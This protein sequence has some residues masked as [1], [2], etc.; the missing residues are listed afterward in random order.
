MSNPLLERYVAGDREQVWRD[1]VELG[2][3]V[4]SDFYYPD[5]KAVADETMRRARHNI[6]A[7]VEKLKS[8][9][10]TFGFGSHRAQPLTD[11]LEAIQNAMRHTGA[12]SRME[13]VAGI[14]PSNLVEGLLEKM[15]Q[16]S[17]SGFQPRNA[18]EES[19]ATMTQGIEKMR[20]QFQERVPQMEAM[21]RVQPKAAPPFRA[22]SKKIA[23]ELD[24]LEKKQ[25]GP[26]PISLRAW[27]ES[28]GSVDLTGIHEV[29]SPYGADDTCGALQ[30]FQFSDSLKFAEMMGDEDDESEGMELTL[31]AADG[32]QYTVQVP[33]P[34]ADAELLGWSQTFVAHL[35]ETFAWG[36]F[37]DWKGRAE[38]PQKEID[39][40]REGLLPL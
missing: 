30:V 36:G 9:G 28:I 21:P 31:W 10:Y 3:A 32:D 11:P 5:A 7:L 22:P 6:E 38:R 17:Q 35:R 23:K 1:L 26:L 15:K 16:F 39:F 25:G 13:Q 34:A 20:A 18:Y 24:S 2:P 29:V 4:R 8:L 27:Y 40:L 33:D 14:N 37:A 12:I 19:M